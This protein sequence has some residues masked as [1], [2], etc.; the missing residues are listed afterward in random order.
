MNERRPLSFEVLKMESSLTRNKIKIKFGAW[1]VSNKMTPT[2]KK[3]LKF[4]K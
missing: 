2:Q 1:N 4:A 3:M